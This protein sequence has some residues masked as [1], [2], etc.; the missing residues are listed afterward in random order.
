MNCDGGSSSLEYYRLTETVD[1]S[2]SSVPLIDYVPRN[3]LPNRPS[4]LYLEKEY[5]KTV[6]INVGSPMSKY[7]FSLRRSKKFIQQTFGSSMNASAFRTSWYRNCFH[8]VFQPSD[9]ILKYITPFL[10]FFNDHYMIGVH[11]RMRDN[12][13]EWEEKTPYLTMENVTSQMDA[14][15]RILQENS[16][17]IVYLATDSRVVEKMM[18]N[19]FSDRLITAGNLPL[20][21]TGN[22]TNEAGSLRAFMDLY[23]LSRCQTL[24]LTKKSLLSRVAYLASMNSPIVYYFW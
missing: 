1:V 2:N 20:M 5:D 3:F 22:L 9:F 18:F 12:S 24:F 17:A 8:S 7:L 10:N 6:A 23:L 15:D 11:V 14:I 13:S 16:R 21:N 19:R 4:P